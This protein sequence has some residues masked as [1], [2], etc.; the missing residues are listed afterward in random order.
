[1]EQTESMKGIIPGQPSKIQQDK[2]C[3]MNDI[4]EDININ[5]RQ[6][7]NRFYIYTRYD[8]DK[9]IY[10]IF[11]NINLNPNEPPRKNEEPFYFLITIT[12]KYPQRPPFL[13]C[14]SPVCINIFILI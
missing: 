6:S 2:Q 3:L 5:I 11:I 4:S 1:M 12:S 10:K 7:D 9:V 8:P 13:Q 14:L